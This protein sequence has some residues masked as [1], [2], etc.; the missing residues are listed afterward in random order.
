M[1][2]IVVNT[3]NDQFCQILQCTCNLARQRIMM[4]GRKKV[5]DRQKQAHGTGGSEYT[6]VQCHGEA[7]CCFQNLNQ[8]L[9][10][11]TMS[12]STQEQ[13]GAGHLP[14][15]YLLLQSHI[16][17]RKCWQKYCTWIKYILL[18]KANSSTFQAVDKR[19]G[20]LCRHRFGTVVFLTSSIP[21]ITQ[22]VWH[23]GNDVVWQQTVKDGFQWTH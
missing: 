21:V 3:L 13:A 17:T 11:Q 9:Y 2:C 10:H 22:V 12:E 5:W 8:Y 20:K 4:F 23:S 6:S 15:E 7:S 19:L 16:N 14:D 18:P 1:D